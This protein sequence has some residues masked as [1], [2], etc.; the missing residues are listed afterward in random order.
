MLNRDESARNKV[1]VSKHE[2]GSYNTE[3]LFNF[4]DIT[5]SLPLYQYISTG[6]KNAPVFNKP[7]SWQG[8]L[9]FAESLIDPNQNGD[10][11]R[12]EI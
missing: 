1:I 9:V 2:L 11:W 10:E 8:D 3:L 7:L 5:G 4:L 12:N 6:N